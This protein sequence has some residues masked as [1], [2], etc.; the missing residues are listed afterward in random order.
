MR[1]FYFWRLFVWFRV[2]NAMLFPIFIY[3]YFLLAIIEIVVEC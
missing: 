2:R 1:W 3:F